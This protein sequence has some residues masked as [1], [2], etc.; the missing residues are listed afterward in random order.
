MRTGR[1]QQRNE[2]AALVGVDVLIEGSLTEFGRNVTGKKGLLSGTKLQTA[3][4]MIG[5]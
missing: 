5:G 2:D 3:Y 1:R 4:T